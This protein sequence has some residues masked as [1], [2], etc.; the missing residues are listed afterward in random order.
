MIRL[1]II[2]LTLIEL[3]FSQKAFVGMNTWTHSQTVGLT[4]GGYLF[5]TQN[6]FRN[7]AM[8]TKSNRYFKINMIKYPAQINGQSLMTNGK[9]NK[10][11]FGLKLNRINYGFFE[12][13]N[14]NNQVEDD[15]SAGETHLKLVYAKFSNS[16]R[17]AIGV[18][19]GLFFSSIDNVNANALT[20]SPGAVFFSRFGQL[21]VSLQNSG[22]TLNSY[23]KK[24]AKLPSSIVTSLAGK[25][26]KMPLEL[27][28]DHSYSLIDQ[29]SVFI[30]SGL[31]HLRNRLIIKGGTSTNKFDQI[32]D[33]SFITNFFSDVGFGVSYEFED[34]LFDLNAHSYGPGGFTFAFGLSV[35]Y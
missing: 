22:L 11:Y 13:R 3:G 19:S 8:L 26:E 20:I 9:W 5:S 34:V 2:I 29:Q 28:V 16:E 33:V 15:Y 32:T 6:E 18:T 12:G 1:L 10:H 35:R 30:F 27:E 21:G 23:T 25:I 4:G 31:L 17:F 14:S 7:P 24:K